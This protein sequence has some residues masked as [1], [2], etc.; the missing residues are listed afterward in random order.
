[1]PVQVVSKSKDKPKV[2][3]K[4]KSEE[5]MLVDAMVELDTQIQPVKPLIKEYDEKRKTLAS[6][7]PTEAA[8]DKAYHFLGTNHMVEFSPCST[9]KSVSV[10]NLQVIRKLLGED[11]FWQIIKVNVSDLERYLTGE[12]FETLVVESRTGPRNHK[13][14]PLE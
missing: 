10:D 7:I 14:K 3:I 2:V 6:L 1:M 13:L 8:K 4:K 5:S 12:Q 11:V 9:M